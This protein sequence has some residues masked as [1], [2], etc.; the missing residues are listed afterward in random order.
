MTIEKKL[1]NYLQGELK[2]ISHKSL[3]RTFIGYSNLFSDQKL[4][5]IKDILVALPEQTYPNS[6]ANSA[7]GLSAKKGSEPNRTAASTAASR[8]SSRNDQS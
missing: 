4:Q 8:R 7:A 6:M 5:V 2:P 1:N 3:N